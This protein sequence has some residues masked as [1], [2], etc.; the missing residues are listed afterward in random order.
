MVWKN[1]WYDPSLKHHTPDG[2]RNTHSTGHQPGD[3][4]RWQKERKAAGLPKPPSSGYDAFIQTWWQP[5]ELN[6]R[7]EDGAWWLGHASVLL[8]MDGRYLLTD[9]VFSHR[10]SPV[11][12]LGPQRKTPP[13]IT[14]ESLPPL[15]AL[16]ISHNH[17]DHLDAATVRKLLRRFPGL[18]VFVPLGLGDW[19]RR[20]GAKN[21]VEL[22]WW[23]NAHW[24]GINLTA[25]PAQHWSMR[26][27]WN[28]NRSLW[29][30]WVV[31]GRQHRFWFS[32]DTGY[33]P[34]LL[35]IP[36]RLGAIDFA[37]LPIGA[38]APEWFMAVHHMNPHSAVAL[39]QGLGCPTAF[40]IHW[41]VFELADESLDEPV[42][43]LRRALDNVAPVNNSF[44]ILKIGEYLSV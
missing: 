22:D 39:W 6:A 7:P 35:L 33:S 8:R 30:G 5:V 2:F 13:A 15:D 16:L 4:D 32:G 10:A 36:E 25:V 3:V 17:Y 9:P 40:P 19:F 43:A 23:Q 38:Y 29:C 28:R 34:E 24:Q 41:G 31:E 44:R 11:P 37:A 14:V 21:V 26:T 12:F 20:R 18:I 1:P 42:Q 27:P